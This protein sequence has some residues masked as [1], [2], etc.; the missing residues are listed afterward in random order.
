MKSGRTVAAVAPNFASSLVG[1]A[2]TLDAMTE[3]D[4]KN[5]DDLTEAELADYHN[6]DVDGVD[7]LLGPVPDGAG[8]RPAELSFPTTG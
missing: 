4:A 5:H 8:E 1:Y 3:S 2:P 7:V 6:A